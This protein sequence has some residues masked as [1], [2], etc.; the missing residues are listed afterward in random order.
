MVTIFKSY[1]YLPFIYNPLIIL[2]LLRIVTLIFMGITFP[3]PTAPGPQPHLLFYGPRPKLLF[4]GSPASKITISRPLVI[5]IIVC[6]VF[7]YSFKQNSAYSLFENS[8]QQNVLSY[9]NP[10]QCESTGCFLYDQNCK[11]FLNRLEIYKPNNFCRNHV[12]Q[13]IYFT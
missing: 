6:H 10:L 1:M 12:K 4:P 3:R 13:N 9:T 8:F 2:N 11:L 5:I 7:I